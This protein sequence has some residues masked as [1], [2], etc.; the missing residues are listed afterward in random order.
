MGLRPLA[1]AEF[2]PS[3]PGE[4]GRRLPRSATL[5]AQLRAELVAEAAQDALLLPGRIGV[6]ERPIWRLVA[7]GEGER[8]LACADAIAAVLVEQCD[9]RD[10][11]RPRN[12]GEQIGRRHILVDDE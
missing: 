11:F 4:R 10:R 3:A 2:N 8:L 5:P 6:G 7:D 9:L 12:G 1:A